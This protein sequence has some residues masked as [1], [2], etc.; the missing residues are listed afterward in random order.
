MNRLIQ[1]LFRR[2]VHR[3]GILT[4]EPA[5]VATRQ[6]LT[7]CLE[8]HREIATSVYLELRIDHLEEDPLGRIVMI[9]APADVLR[10]RSEESDEWRPPFTQ[11]A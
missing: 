8:A 10:T 7:G 2:D 9:G 6:A 3:P 11:L 5:A 4:I 1:N